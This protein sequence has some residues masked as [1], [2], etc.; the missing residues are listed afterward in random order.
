VKRRLLEW[1]GKSKQALEC[2]EQC[3]QLNPNYAYADYGMGMV[4]AKNEDYRK[5]TELLRKAVRLD[6]GFF[7]GRIALAD[8]LAGLNQP[9]EVIAILEDHVRRDPR[10]QGFFLL[11]QAYFQ[12][13]QFEKARENLEAA[14][15]RYPKYGEAYYRL[16]AVYTRLGQQ[17][18]AGQCIQ[19]SRELKAEQRQDERVKK[20]EYDDLNAVRNR[21]AETY[22]S[23]GRLYLTEKKHIEA[24]RL[25]RRAAELSPKNVECRQGLAWLCR[26]QVRIPETIAI[27]EQL[28]AIQP[29]DPGIWLEIGRL[30][31]ELNQYATAE[32][33]MARAVELEPA[34]Q[35]SRAAYESLKKERQGKK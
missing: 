29:K 23:A 17:D 28:A 15:Q 10:S 3:L 33:A 13:Q 27:L 34:N 35:Q 16:S 6:P 18:K 31:A 22:T 2:W 5:A 1:L 11:G 9:K 21:V 8:A 12:M 25:W 19:K 26:E 30:H 4:A 32:S 24:E 20:K 14:I 7:P